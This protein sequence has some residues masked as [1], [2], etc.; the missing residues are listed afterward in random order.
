MNWQGPRDKSEFSMIDNCFLPANDAKEEEQKIEYPEPYEVSN[1]PAM[2]DA[3][4]QRML[5]MEA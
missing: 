3:E 1:P 5:D 4:Y 2:T